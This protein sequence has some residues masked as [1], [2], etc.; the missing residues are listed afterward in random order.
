MTDEIPR[1]GNVQH[2]TNG[3]DWCIKLNKQLIFPIEEGGK[4]AGRLH[5]RENRK[6][7]IHFLNNLAG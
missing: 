1:R 5:L 2:Q 4:V 7:L 6:S 3:E